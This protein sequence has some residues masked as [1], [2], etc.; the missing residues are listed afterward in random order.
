MARLAAYYQEDFHYPAAGYGP[1]QSKSAYL[2]YEGLQNNLGHSANGKRIRGLTA[3]EPML[4][5]KFMHPA[6]ADIMSLKQ[7]P[8]MYGSQLFESPHISKQHFDNVCNAP[9]PNNRMARY[10]TGVFDSD[11]ISSFG[12]MPAYDN[13]YTNRP[14]S[15]HRD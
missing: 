8:M 2:V 9:V 1:K 14:R 5:P 12:D 10:E 15:H 7:R 11:S 4:S 6:D 3:S 13:R